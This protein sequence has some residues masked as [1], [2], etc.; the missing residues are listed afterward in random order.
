LTCL[1]VE[2]GELQIRSVQR[3]EV[4]ERHLREG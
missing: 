3:V 4:V 2:R 1:G